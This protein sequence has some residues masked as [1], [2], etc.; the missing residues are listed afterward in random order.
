MASSWNLK[1][2]QRLRW[3]N[4]ALAFLAPGRNARTASWATLTVCS[5]LLLFPLRLFVIDVKVPLL[6][7]ASAE[8]GFRMRDVTKAFVTTEQATSATTE[9]RTCAS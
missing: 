6:R 9:C 1:P 4:I 3:L 7:T 5:M 2:S 8:P